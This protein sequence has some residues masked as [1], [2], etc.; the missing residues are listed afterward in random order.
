MCTKNW[1]SRSLA[2]WTFVI[3]S[4]TLGGLSMDSQA[5]AHYPFHHHHCGF[6]Y[7]GWGSNYYG[8]YSS[9]YNLQSSYYYPSFSFGY[10]PRYY[11]VN[12]YTPTYFAPVYYAPVY[13]PPVY[14]APACNTWS[15]INDGV[16][17]PVASSRSPTI[18]KT[19]PL[20][21][22]TRAI[23][24]ESTLPGIQVAKVRQQE[25]HENALADQHGIQLVSHKPMLLQPY[26][27][28]WT[29]AAVGIVDDMIAAGELDSAHSSC[30]SMER[31]KQSKGAGVYLRQALLN[32]FSSEASSSQ[33]PSTEEVLN[34]LEL[35]CEAGSQVQPSELSKNSLHEYFAA[36]AVDVTAAMEQL[37]QSVLEAPN[38][39]A[40]ELLL[41]T[42][43]LKLEGQGDKA[44]LFAN[45][46]NELA[47][48]SG[49]F[50]WNRLL[51]VCL[52]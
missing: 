18:Q 16:G 21:M 32:Y 42:A 43:L 24:S 9:F 30:K 48:K 3:G 23:Q 51:E 13:Y 29:K 17:F 14:Y 40:R 39:S 12:Y 37:S 52:N 25:N 50:R 44:R 33:K 28:I 2:K 1:F 49:S 31:I 26:S 7:H 36:C 45:E 6:G 22:R 5:L 46:I 15:S 20:A 27:P 8:G 47:S 34:L 10:V 41:L 38:H 35:A 4:A 19:S 11:S